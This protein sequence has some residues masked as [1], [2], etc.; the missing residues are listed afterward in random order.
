MKQLMS[1][2]TE[3]NDDVKSGLEISGLNAKLKVIVEMSDVLRLVKYIVSIN[4][5]TMAATKFS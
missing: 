1:N 4:N 5:N 3:A 2:Y